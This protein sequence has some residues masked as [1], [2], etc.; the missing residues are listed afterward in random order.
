MSDSRRLT[1]A[2]V[3]HFNKS[4]EAYV[5]QTTNDDSTKSA[6]SRLAPD[7]TAL[8]NLLTAE[9]FKVNGTPDLTTFTA[10]L[11]VKSRDPMGS[12]NMVQQEASLWGGSIS[13]KKSLLQFHSSGYLAP[14][15][16][17]E[18]DGLTS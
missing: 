11:I 7:Q 18:P 16:N 14:G 10:K 2:M 12:I 8:F 13:E 9:N 15:L 4:S 1:Q 17:Q 3:L 5:C 6:L